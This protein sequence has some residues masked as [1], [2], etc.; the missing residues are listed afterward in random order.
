M[1]KLIF[2]MSSALMLLSA[3]QMDDSNTDYCLSYQ[4]EPVTAV[5]PIPGV[6]AQENNSFKVDFNSTNGCGAFDSFD[7]TSDGNTRV[8][9]VIG[10]YVGC[11][12][13]QDLPARE[14]TYTFTETTPGTYTLKFYQSDT[15][16]ITHTVVIP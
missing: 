6:P 13:T 4:T 2:A 5:T 3:C 15:A 14:A 10:K 8:I 16:F 7:V 12:C 9:K 1:K 11:V